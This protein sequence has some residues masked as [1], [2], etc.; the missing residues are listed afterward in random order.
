MSALISGKSRFV[1]GFW[2]KAL[3]SFLMLLAV[4]DLQTIAAI[5]PQIA[6]GVGSSATAVSYSFVAYSLA[7]VAAAW[8]L[9]SHPKSLGNTRLLPAAAFVY[10]ISCWLAIAVP[11]I[12]AFFA[13]R[14]LAGMAGGFISALSITA[15]ANVTSY[16]KRGK[17]MSLIS[18][19]YY[20][21]PMLG[22]PL[23]TF[24]TDLY[25]WRLVFI[26]TGTLIFLAGLL[27]R[28]APLSAPIKNRF[29]SGR[30]SFDL[31]GSLRMGVISAFFVS[32]GLVGF[33]T[34]IGTWLYQSWGSNPSRV[35]LAYALMNLG[36]LAGGI[37]GGFLA[38]RFGKRS[39]ALYPN[40]IMALGL[41]LLPVLIWKSALLGLISLVAFAAA[42]RVAPLQAL[43]T[44]LARPDEIASYIATRNIA[45]QLGIG[46]SILV[47]GQIYFTY[48]LAGV[49]VACGTLTLG[50]WLTIRAITEPALIGTGE[51]DE[52]ADL[53]GA[54]YD[55]GEN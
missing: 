36:A 45:S 7:A 43:L 53:S 49:S 41:F 2:G 10:G 46:F 21:A 3:L 15:L 19:S 33:T 34:F 31:S 22:V 47:G 27:I 50:A 24:L 54:V 40:L 42:L 39:M 32:G 51:E 35:G 5:T 37:L 55:W 8:L 20:M 12:V 4:T 38:D 17:N 23:S 18:F 30:E 28:L 52:E 25:G 16:E 1:R 6:Q 11:G 13:A 14:I 26:I 29:E 44:E 9:R 48:G